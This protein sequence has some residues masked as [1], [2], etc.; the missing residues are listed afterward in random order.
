LVNKLYDML[1]HPHRSGMASTVRLTLERANF[2]R[3]TRLLRQKWDLVINTLFLPPELIAHMHRINRVRIPQVTVVT[4]FD[5]QGLW[6]H[7]PCE[8]Y[9]VA[10][11]EAR[12][13]TASLGID[14]ARVHVTG[15]PID[16]VFTQRKERDACRRKHRFFCDRPLML[17]MA[18][19]V[20]IGS[21][22]Q[23]YRS[24]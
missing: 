10:P 7:P 19:G 23:I 3:L 5:V 18:G 17:Q 22:E 2:T 1:N 12:A 15:I 16:P 4:D 6:M 21:M 13:Y 8:V 11:P 9:F 20:G 24:L 14:P